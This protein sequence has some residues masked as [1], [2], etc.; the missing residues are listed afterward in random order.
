MKNGKMQ[1][2]GVI[3]DEMCSSM[4]AFS[5]LCKQET[6]GVLWVTEIASDFST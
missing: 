4:D 5:Y 3:F 1:G 6:K 2:R